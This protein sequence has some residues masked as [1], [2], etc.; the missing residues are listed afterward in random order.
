LQH[1]MRW[2]CV[3]GKCRKENGGIVL[4]ISRIERVAI[5]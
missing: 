4:L 1:L 5:H 3:S 2:D